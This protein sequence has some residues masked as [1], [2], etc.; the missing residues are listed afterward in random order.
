M[1]SK[2]I[3]GATPNGGVKSTLFYLDAA[4]VETE[5]DKAEKLMIVEYNE[6]GEPIQRTYADAPRK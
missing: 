1:A 4:G 6:A 2:T 3:D 5:A